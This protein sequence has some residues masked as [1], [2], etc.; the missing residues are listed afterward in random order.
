MAWTCISTHF[1]HKTAQEEN[2]FTEKITLQYREQ[3]EAQD[4]VEILPG[5]P[6]SAADANFG[7]TLTVTFRRVN[8]QRIRN[9]RIISTD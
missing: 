2:I 7:R 5:T 1:R 9:N 3:S 6:M 8:Y 4:R